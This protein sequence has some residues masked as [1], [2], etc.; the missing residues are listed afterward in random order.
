MENKKS[1]L[2][3]LTLT[4]SAHLLL[5]ANL[6]VEEEVEQQAKPLPQITKINLQNV[7]IKKPEPV[8]EPIVEKPVEIKP[9]P[10]TESTNKIKEVKKKDFP[11]KEKKVEKKIEEIKEVKQEI[12]NA[13]PQM[14]TSDIKSVEKDIDPSLKDALENEYLAKIRMI[15]EKNK[16]YPKSAKRLN[17]M[18]KVNVCFVISKDG[19]IQ[20]IKVVK[21]SSFER[22]DEAAIEILT[23]INSFEPIPEKLN[24]NSWEITVPIVYQITRS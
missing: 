6:K 21:K 1:L 9:L 19:H 13:V 20:D 10:K 15:I 12:N 16:I 2:V 24:K 4:I 11:K 7:V 23:K 18:G 14:N 5:F 3:I 8:V 22:L 17:Q